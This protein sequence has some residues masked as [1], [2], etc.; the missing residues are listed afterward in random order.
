MRDK[1]VKTD[2]SDIESAVTNTVGCVND[3]LHSMFSSLS[4]SLIGKSVTLH[5]TNY[6]Y[7]AYLEKLLNYDSDASGTHLVSGFWYLD[8][9]QNSNTSVVTSDG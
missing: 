5:E 4:I 7:K 1:L 3:I 9:L 2:G 8:S 6:H